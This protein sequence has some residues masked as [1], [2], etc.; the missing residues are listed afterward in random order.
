MLTLKQCF[1]GLKVR[2]IDN[3]GMNAKIGS[4]AT[5]V[6]VPYK[7]DYIEIKWDK[8]ELSGSQMDGGY[9]PKHFSYITIP[10]N[11]NL[12]Q[13]VEIAIQT[14]RSYYEQI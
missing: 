12:Q 2:L 9:E 4:T 1:V 7:S 14:L 8:N 11:M 3:K 10:H 13:T 6:K 5:I